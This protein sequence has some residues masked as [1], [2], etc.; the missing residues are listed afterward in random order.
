[1]YGTSARPAPFAPPHIRMYYVSPSNTHRASHLHSSTPFLSSTH[2]ATEHLGR[3]FRTCFGT[4]RLAGVGHGP[5]MPTSV[6]G[7]REFPGQA[8]GIVS[9]GERRKHRVYGRECQARRRRPE[10]TLCFGK[11]YREHET[12]GEETPSSF[13]GRRRLEQS[14]VAR[15]S[16][17][18]HRKLHGGEA[19]PSSKDRG[20]DCL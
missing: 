17:C 16:G 7:C 14:C 1:M 5:M 15:D 2:A 10:T 20:E 13:H 9:T 18:T 4:F 19:W 11:R 8:E 12:I 3:R 6:S